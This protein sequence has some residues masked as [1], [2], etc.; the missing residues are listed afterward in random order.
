[1]GKGEF[2]EWCRRRDSHFAVDASGDGSRDEDEEEVEAADSHAAEDA[3]RG[4][5]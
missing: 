5:P 2:R 3:G 4:W 1:M